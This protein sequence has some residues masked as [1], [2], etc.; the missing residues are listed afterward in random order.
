MSDPFID[1]VIFFLF[2]VSVAF[3]GI[4]VTGLF[5]FPDIRSRLYTAVRAT[6]IGNAAM[7]LSV[8]AYA[9]FI[10]VSG[11]GDQY[12]SLVIH[13]FVL[14]CIVIV[15]NMVLYRMVRKKAGIPL[16]CPETRKPEPDRNGP[17]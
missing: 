8:T 14:L 10:F 6:T 4:G 5:L 1:A 3:S 13:T 7:V 9:F 12:S 11:E 2:I 16:A 17:K 15:A